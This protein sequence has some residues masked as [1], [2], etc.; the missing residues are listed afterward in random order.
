MAEDNE[1]RSSKQT[2]ETNDAVSSARMPLRDGRSA[3]PGASAS[4]EKR[5]DSRGGKTPDLKHT[6]TDTNAG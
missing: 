2:T 3:T 5:P 6:S 1:D 4:S